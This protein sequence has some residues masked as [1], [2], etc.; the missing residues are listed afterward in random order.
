[1]RKNGIANNESMT[2]NM[3]GIMGGLDRLGG[4]LQ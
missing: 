3:S 1:M 4:R 2:G